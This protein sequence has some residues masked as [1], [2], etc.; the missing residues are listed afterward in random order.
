MSNSIGVIDSDYYYKMKVTFLIQLYN[1]TSQDV[2]VTKG[3][4][5]VQGIFTLTI[6][7]LAMMRLKIK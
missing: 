3:E 7:K 1:I 6:I 5:L 4:R 2:L